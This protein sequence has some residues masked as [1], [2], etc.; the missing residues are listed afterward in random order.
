VVLVVQVDHVKL[1][2][3]VV[4]AV[5]QEV[6]AVKLLHHQ[7][8]HI[9]MPLVEQHPVVR[10]AQM[11]IQ[12][13]LVLLVLLLLLL[14]INK[15]NVMTFEVPIIDLTAGTIVKATDVYPAVDV[16]DT[17]EAPSGTTKA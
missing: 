15:D 1:A 8:Q 11:E 17:T 9:V 5:A 16:T 6:T 13:A 14:I 2:L 12:V 3:L 7:V 10:Q 4:G